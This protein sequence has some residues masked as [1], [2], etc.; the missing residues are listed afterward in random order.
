MSFATKPVK[1]YVPWQP[2][3]DFVNWF[4]KLKHRQISEPE[5]D[6]LKVTESATPSAPQFLQ[7]SNMRRYKRSK[8]SNTVSKGAKSLNSKSRGKSSSKKRRKIR[9]VKKKTS[10][11]H[12]RRGGKK[13][14]GGVREKKRKRKS[15]KKPKARKF[16]KRKIILE[17][18]IDE[19][20]FN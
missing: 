11:K 9:K 20:S 3:T 5:T 12:K 16:G 1:T 10:K 18:N 14:T 15:T 7:K 17:K 13:T 6:T 2:N 4:Q 8:K 19:H